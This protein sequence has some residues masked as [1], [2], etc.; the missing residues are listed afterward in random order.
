MG[1]GSKKQKA[2]LA[3]FLVVLVVLFALYF[4]KR[5]ID[6]VALSSL[7]QNNASTSTVSNILHDK[8]LPPPPGS[9]H[10]PSLKNGGIVFFL[11]IPKTGGT[12]IRELVKYKKGGRRSDV[13]YIYLTGPR[14]Y[15]YTVD[16][17]HGWL[18]N[19][20]GVVESTSRNINNQLPAADGQVVFIEYHPL[21]RNCPTFL[22]LSQTILPEW[23]RL[24]TLNN[25]PFFVL[26]L[27]RE[28][29]SLAVSFFNFYHA[30][31]QNPKRFYLIASENT[32]EDVFLQATIANPQCLFLSRNEDAYTKTGKD[33]RD[34]LK[35]NDCQEA[36]TRLA[37]LFDW[38]GTTDR[39]RD[40][41][42]PL[43]KDLFSTNRYTKGLIQDL[44]KTANPSSAGRS[45][46]QKAM[47]SEKAWDDIRNKTLWD[48][49]LYNS[50]QHDFPF[51]EWARAA[52]I[53]V[54]E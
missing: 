6:A 12:T 28:P 3:T 47:L 26:S 11:H 14:E 13:K 44:N 15:K 48:S 22:D 4:D 45:P 34:S 35:W 33:L 36:Y 51:N 9:R 40:E 49:L 7:G 8:L 25:V 10:P 42:L 52:I 41:T 38:I 37:D 39:I 31:E 1:E 5:I 50:I 21:D 43:L 46:I 19:G 23:K 29:I 17:M 20:T 53:P 16:Q 24:A 27:I 30:M 2:I 32:T 18:V 54:E